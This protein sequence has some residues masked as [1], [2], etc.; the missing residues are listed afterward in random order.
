MSDQSH[1]LEDVMWVTMINA[2]NNLAF[3]HLVE[4]YQGSIYNLCYRMLGEAIEAEDAAQEVFL[5]A[6]TKLDSYDESR[7]FSTWLFAIATHYCLDKLRARRFQWVSWDGLAGW[8]RISRTE[9]S[10]L[11]ENILLKSEAR[12]AV[13]HLLATLP[14]AY[15]APIIL[16][17]WHEMSY[18]DIAQT[19][20][21]SISA[22]KSKLFRARKMMA[23]TARASI[24]EQSALAVR[25][26]FME[27]SHPLSPIVPT[28]QFQLS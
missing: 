25:D 26:I 4:K 7:K 24:S 11:P 1:N 8:S 9:E 6:Y 3:K 19:L 21:T 23:Q 28:E 20:D 14:A 12:Q 17:Y 2:G 18:A 27:L 13:Y 16:K 15:R 22:I 10:I 5:R